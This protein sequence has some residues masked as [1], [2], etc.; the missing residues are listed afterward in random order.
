MA[1]LLERVI[2]VSYENLIPIIDHGLCSFVCAGLTN[3]YRDVTRRALP[4]FFIGRVM[5]IANWPKR[6]FLRTLGKAGAELAPF[7]LVFYLDVRV[8]DQVVVPS[9]MMRRTT[10]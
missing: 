8:L 6:V 7:A 4:V 9:R 1:V 2:V 3:K 5:P 10:R